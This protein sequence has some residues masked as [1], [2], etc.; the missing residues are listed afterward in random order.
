MNDDIMTNEELQLLKDMSPAAIKAIVAARMASNPLFIKIIG[1][2]VDE[3]L[4]TGL[5]TN[6]KFTKEYGGK[7]PTDILIDSIAS[8][9]YSSVLKDESSKDGA[10]YIGLDASAHPALSAATNV[11]DALLAIANA[12]TALGGQIIVPKKD[13]P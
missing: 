4:Y 6:P 1:R 12:V 7:S 2:L 11:H 8:T 3:K 13:T 5:Q 9:L 10:S